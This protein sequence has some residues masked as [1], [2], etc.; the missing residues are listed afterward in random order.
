M[1]LSKKLSHSENTQSNITINAQINRHD[2][3]ISNLINGYKKFY[4]EYLTNHNDLSQIYK[5]L[6]SKGQFPKALFVACSDSRIDPAIV[7][8]AQPGDIFAIRNVANLVPPYQNDMSTYH[9]TSSAIE[10][11]VNNLGIENLVVMGHTYCAGVRASVA[12]VARDIMSND[13]FVEKIQNKNI[14]ISENVIDLLPIEV[15]ETLKVFSSNIQ[16]DTEQK[17]QNYITFL[18]NHIKSTKH[19]NLSQKN[20]EASFVNSW[21]KIATDVIKKILEEK[22]E[23]YIKNPDDFADYCAMELVKSSLNNLRQFPFIQSKLANK[24]LTLHGWFFDIKTASMMY[25]DDCDKQYKAII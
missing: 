10:F 11:G 4:N 25:Y 13:K 23:D 1:K 7:T 6:V 16:I 5:D 19:K 3:K 9:G 22:F 8:K 12:I 14:V 17:K 15:V 24:E 21:I 18:E 2:D 20:N